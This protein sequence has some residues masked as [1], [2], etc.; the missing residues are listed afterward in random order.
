MKV[1]SR[2]GDNFEVVVE[3]D[4]IG[5]DNNKEGDDFGDIED[6]RKVERDVGVEENGCK[7]RMKK[8]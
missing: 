8:S 4:E 2:I 1:G 3:G 6:V 5:D 7:M